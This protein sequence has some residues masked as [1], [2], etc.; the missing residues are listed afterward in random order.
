MDTETT[1]HGEYGPYRQS[2]RK[3]IYQA[4]AKYLLEQGKAYPCFATAEE[5]EEMRKT[6]EVAGVKPGYYGVWAKYRNLTVEEAAEKIKNGEHYIIRLRSN[7]SEERKIKVHDVIKGN[8]IFPENDQD[9]VIIKADGL[10]T[11]HFAHLVDDH[12]MGTTT[13]TRGEEWLSSLPIHLELFEAMGWKAPDYA[14]LP[15][16]MKVDEN[17]N[18]RKLSKRKDQEAAV[19]YFIEHGYPVEG[20]IKYL[21][22]I[23]NSNFE[24]W[25]RANPKEDVS[26]FNFTFE[27]MSLDGALFDLPKLRNISK[28][29]LSYLD[30]PTISK[31]AT[32][33][34]QKYDPKL[35]N[36][37]SKDPA[38]FEK[39]MNIERNQEHPRKDYDVY[40]DI[41]EKIKFFDCDIYDELFE[42]TELP[43]NPFIDK[44]II[45]TIL[46][47]FKDSLNLDQEESS[48]FD[49]LKNLGAKH[50]F[51]LSF[52]EYKKDKEHFIGHVG[53][54]AEMVRIALTTS[55][56]S[57]N[58]FQ[59]M[60]ILG[61]EE[62]SR[63]IDKTLNSKV[64]A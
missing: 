12:F 16:I 52:K 19:S 7:G 40:S 32:E 45:K 55:K 6:Q 31:N 38:K 22:T 34:A 8:V 44:N 23:A 58:L 27:K 26:K 50:G 3:E 21:L 51:A 25:L 5:L 1:W 47:E 13:I 10:P 41:Y 14:H 60:K 46:V 35:Y 42:N 11:Y 39:I 18:R 33:Y 17:G 62:V 4:Y 59:S 30:A 61:K 15:V 56:N 29:V 49:S 37:I 9:I 2:M 43:F 28:D 48:W 63:R 57:P 36:L 20:I 24:E 54:V 64:L 53:D